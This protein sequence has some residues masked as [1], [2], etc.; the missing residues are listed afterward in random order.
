MNSYKFDNY[1]LTLKNTWIMKG[2]KYQVKYWFKNPDNKV[3]FS[4]NDFYPSPMVKPESKESAKHLLSFLTLQEYDT[5]SEYFDNY[6]DDQLN[7]RDSQDCENLQFY[8]MDD[9]ITDSNR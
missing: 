4:G 5:D 8:T 3:I 1:T 7:F 2:S 9:W 6:T